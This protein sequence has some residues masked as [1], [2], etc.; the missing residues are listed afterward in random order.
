MPIRINQE[1]GT[2]ICLVQVSG[3]LVSADYE[4]LISEFGRLVKQHGKLRV[5]FDMSDFHGWDAGALWQEVK[6]DVKHFGDIERLACVGDQQWQHWITEFCKPFTQ[7]LIRYFDSAN[8][9]AA[10]EWLAEP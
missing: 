1:N 2:K 10:R 3:E 4:H 9:S 5:L 6:F 7:A 8:A